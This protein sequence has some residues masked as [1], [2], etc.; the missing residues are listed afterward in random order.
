M[1]VFILYKFDWEIN[2]YKVVDVYSESGKNKKKQE[3]SQLGEKAY[4]T[5]VEELE[6][7]LKDINFRIKTYEKLKEAGIISKEEKKELENLINKK[8]EVRFE[9]DNL[10]N[11][12]TKYLSSYYAFY[13]YYMTINWMKFISYEV[14]E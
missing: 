2:D 11:Y 4:N 13:F 3:F 10:K 5:R 8:G 9:L 14:K 12:R 1:K 7:Q 6:T